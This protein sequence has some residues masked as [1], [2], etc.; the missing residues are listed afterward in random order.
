MEAAFKADMSVENRQVTE[1]IAWYQTQ[2]DS[3][4][5]LLKSKR[6]AFPGNEGVLFK[7]LVALNR[8]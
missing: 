4:K 6:F 8:L 7:L 1:D 2:P 3:K 5:R